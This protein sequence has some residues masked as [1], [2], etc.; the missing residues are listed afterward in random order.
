MQ[1]R[2]LLVWQRSMVLAEQV[3]RLTQSFPSEQRFVLVAQLQRAA[4]SIPANIAEGHGRKATGAFANHLSIASGSLRELETLLE[5]AGRL[6]FIGAQVSQDLL[7]ETDEIGRML[8]T[9][10][11]RLLARA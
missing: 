2:D 6:E 1:F 4:A 9:L 8:T 3:F 7:N 10:R 11:E 5:L